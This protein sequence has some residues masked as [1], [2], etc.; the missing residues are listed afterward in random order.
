MARPLDDY[1]AKRDFDRTPEPR[2]RR[3]RA[4][5][6][7]KAPA[8]VVH[9]HEARR[10][11]YDLRLEWNGAL[12]S[13][14]VP[15]GFSY[16]P[17]DKHLAVRTEDHPL[18]YEFFDGVIPKGE[19]GAGT[20]TLWDGG[21]Y[22]FLPETSFERGDLKL[23]LRG[24]RL[25]GEWH[26]V[27][28]KQDGGKNWLLFKSK[29]AYA[30]GPGETSL[31]VDLTQAVRRALPR[32]VRRMKPGGSRAPFSDP[33]WLFEM[34]FAGRRA[35]L[36][37]RGERVRV[38]GLRATPPELAA[39][40]RVLRADEAL[41][42]GCLVCVDDA[43]R[44]S[45]ERLDARLS[46]RADVELCFY[47]F[48]LLHY[49]EFDLRARPLALRKAALR[50]VTS[51]CR[52][53]LFVDHV[54]AE[55]ERLAATVA[56]AGLPGV[57]AKRSDA[58]YAAGP[59]AD[60][61]RV[62]VAPAKARGNV[63]DVLAAGRGSVRSRVR[64]TNTGK[65]F[66]PAE[67]LTKG[68]LLAYYDRVADLLLPHLRERPVHL[69][70]FPDGIEGKSFYQRE[71]KPDTPAWVPTASIP[72]ESKG[73]SK[74]DAVPQF[75][76]G[77]RETLLYLINLGSIDLHPWMSRL[78]SLDSP[79]WC[80]IDLDPKSAPFTSVVRIARTVGKILRGCGL[81]PLLKTSGASGLH[82]YVPLA[83]GYSYEQSRMFAELVARC[84]VRE[85]PDLATVER[86][87][88]SRDGKVYLDYLQNHRGD[89]V[90]PPY[91][92]RPV[93]GAS[94]STPLEWDELEGDLHPSSFTLRT[95]PARFERVGDLFGAARTDGQD[96]LP[97]LER[98]TTAGG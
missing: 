9:R 44:P 34:E 42:D 35:W 92:V 98:L 94:V 85:H 32:S 97:A 40:A 90:V 29:D 4:K 22:E 55:G 28:T 54:A 47:A 50:S 67:G 5:A 70:R 72:S 60:W 25:R 66:W 96:L 59:S 82:V 12:A 46:G 38:R 57:V 86:R 14:A 36:E 76:C 15:K 95:A 7:A 3:E 1:R 41:I 18:E 26:L 21:T 69:N 56:D 64:P 30:G 31:G 80:V 89:T 75:V 20:M 63:R 87:V 62:A 16:D 79:D 77:E 45:R 65:V 24:R 43:G 81:R 51:R 13:W 74:G 17:A 8:F 71:A 19:Y 37:K 10:L 27:R 84:A 53:V 61:V 91:V 88:G 73:E 49:D 58:P 23:V 48:D 93:P 2:G 11:H 83:P 78:A 33:E 6:G 39:D 52:R 68:D